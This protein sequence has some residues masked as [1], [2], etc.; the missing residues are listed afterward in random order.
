MDAVDPLTEQALITFL[1]ALSDD[2]PEAA[3]EVM[4]Q[5]LL[6]YESFYEAFGPIQ[7]LW[8]EKME[9]QVSRSGMKANIETG[10]KDYSSTY[11]V[12]K[13]DGTNFI[14]TISRAEYATGQNGVYN[15]V[16]QPAA[17]YTP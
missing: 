6:D 11:I 4:L 1:D 7:E 17:T 3:Y 13:S 5:E 10:F 16:L 8:G 12:T 14:V 15:V 9:Y 2:D